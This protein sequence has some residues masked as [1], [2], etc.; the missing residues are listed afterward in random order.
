MSDTE[1]LLA[2][3]AAATALIEILGWG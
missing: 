1:A 3:A 2:S